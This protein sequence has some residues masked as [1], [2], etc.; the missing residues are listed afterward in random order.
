MTSREPHLPVKSHS[1]LVENHSSL[2]R[3]GAPGL[4]YL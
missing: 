2:V 3:D 1:S 4:L